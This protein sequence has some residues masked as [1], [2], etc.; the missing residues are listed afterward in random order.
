M[1]EPLSPQASLPLAGTALCLVAALRLLRRALAPVGQLV[2][3]FAAAALVA[4]AF[5]AALAFLVAAAVSD[6]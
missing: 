3:A 6:R 1:V 2:Q 5:G 4:M